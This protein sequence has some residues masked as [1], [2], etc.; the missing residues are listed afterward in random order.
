MRTIY[1]ML[2][3][4]LLHLNTVS[5]QVDKNDMRPVAERQH[6]LVTHDGKTYETSLKQLRGKIVI[7]DFW[8]GYCVS[9]IR[10]MPKLYDLQRLYGESVVI[11]PVTADGFAQVTKTFARQK[12]GQY[13]LKL[14]TIYE[15]TVLTSVY[16]IRSYP[17]AVWLDRNGDF[18]AKTAGSA[19]NDEMIRYVLK[20]DMRLLERV[21]RMS[22]GQ[23]FKEQDS[24]RDVGKRVDALDF[25]AIRVT[26]YDKTLSS[27]YVVYKKQISKRIRYALVNRTLD[28]IIKTLYGDIDDPKSIH[29]LYDE[30][31][32][33]MEISDKVSKRFKARD[34]LSRAKDFKTQT[35]FRENN[36]FCLF[37]E[38]EDTL[39]Y[40]ELRP[41]ALQSIEKAFG[42]KT[43]IRRSVRPVTFITDVPNRIFKEKGETTVNQKISFRRVSDL[44][45]YINNRFVDE[46]IWVLANTRAMDQ[47]LGVSLDKTKNYAEIVEYLIHMGFGFDVRQHA[48]EV[49]A[50]E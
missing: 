41:L 8:N 7:L 17:E 42:I 45:H 13:E 1:V 27:D 36:L 20:G 26:P 25:F 43:Q 15:D 39:D 32:R 33:R 28:E 30:K 5:G 22:S 10:Q 40:R 35:L 9:C 23:F 46:P 50:V 44:L 18:V 6:H 3:Y 47:S 14:P 29:W 19:V 2:L 37:V 21:S 24:V 16:D 48:L 12:G 49:L 31:N 11:L 38:A 34:S 4:A